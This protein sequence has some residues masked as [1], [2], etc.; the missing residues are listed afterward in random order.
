[1]KKSDLTKLIGK[2]IENWEIVNVGYDGVNQIIEL[3]LHEF[4]LKGDLHSLDYKVY[5]ENFKKI[6]ILDEFAFRYYENEELVNVVE[7]LVYQMQGLN[8]H[9]LELMLKNPE[10]VSTNGV[11]TDWKNILMEIGAFNSGEYKTKLFNELKK[12]YVEYLTNN[13][14]IEQTKV[15]KFFE[16]IAQNLNVQNIGNS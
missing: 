10:S 12:C 2:D 6:K 9:Y 5:S 11:Q 3:L 16:D 7:Q 1:M 4:Q 13:P 15:L 14:S 8:L